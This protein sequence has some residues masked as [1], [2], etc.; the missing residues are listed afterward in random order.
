MSEE[1]K[2]DD[3]WDVVFPVRRDPPR[4][5]RRIKKPRTGEALPQAGAVNIL[6]ESRNATNPPF[7]SSA[8]PGTKPVGFGRTSAQVLHDISR[9]KVRPEE[10]LE[11]ARIH[12]NIWR[13]LQRQAL[14]VSHPSDPAE[15][16]ADE[17][18]DR[19]MRM[20]AG[21]E[22]REGV[23]YGVAPE[24]QVSRSI[25]GELEDEAAGEALPIRIAEGV[26]RTPST[27]DDLSVSRES[28]E[29]I[30]R[31]TSSGG[32]PL[33]NAGFFEERMGADFSGVRVH[34]G[35]EA[36]KAAEGVQAKAFTLGRDVVFGEGQYRPETS[37]GKRLIAH[38]LTHTIQQGSAT[39]KK[40]G[41]FAK[42]ARSVGKLWRQ[43][44]QREPRTP[45]IDA[46]KRN[47]ET[48]GHEAHL[49]AAGLSDSGMA[50]LDLS[51]RVRTIEAISDDLLV[52]DDKERTLV[53]LVGTTPE[54]QARGLQRAFRANRSRLLRRL[55]SVIDFEEYKLYNQAL[56]KL[57]FAGMSPSQALG[58]LQA[59][60]ADH[61]FPWGNVGIVS[62]FYQPRT[63]YEKVE[64]T[65]EGKIYIDFYVGVGPLMMGAAPRTIEPFDTIGIYL[66]QPEEE[67]QGA[68][69]SLFYAPA[70]TLFY[71]RSV[72]EKRYAQ[73]IAELSLLGLGGAGIVGAATRLGRTIAALELAVGAAALVIDEYRSE[74][75]RSEEG[76]E[77]LKTWDITQT[78]IAVYSIVRLVQQA[79]QVFRRLGDAY[80][81]FRNARRLPPEPAGKLESEVEEVIEKARAAE[82]EAARDPRRPTEP[83]RVAESEQPVTDDQRQASQVDTP[84]QNSQP[85]QLPSPSVEFERAVAILKNS[86]GATGHIGVNYEVYLQKTL[87]GSGSFKVDGREF[88]GALGDLWY[89]A[90]SGRFWTMTDMDDFRSNIGSHVAIAKRHGKDFALF[91]NTPI[92]KDIKLWLNSK[93]IRYFET[94]K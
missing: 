75:A 79:P 69:G 6:P 27:D 68:N 52:G 8:I 45:T 16:E 23:G 50:M 35:P 59:L 29:Q 12:R 71:L 44:V 32:K 21:R 40:G 46:L 80:R 66:L 7:Y 51:T 92:P 72:Q 4:I 36:A 62:A 54:S 9:A 81:K 5:H 31:V 47:L 2:Q 86:D 55:Q 24:G 14:T 63:H 61:K 89:E 19:V 58:A 67:L 57:L 65:A 13:H 83:E 30:S 34:T 77:F 78:L 91:S 76:R 48:G 11:I 82:A 20:P 1:Q 88:D 84:R 25:D 28:A 85:G 42:L 60:P 64:W 43:V 26:S 74:I 87:G 15:K 49:L 17:M 41:V 70:L 33:E 94:L 38:E 39:P 53:R 93:G 22:G 73:L 90:K 18:A 10:D 56:R 3:E 37:D